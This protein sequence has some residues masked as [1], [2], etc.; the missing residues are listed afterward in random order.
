MFLLFLQIGLTLK[1]EQ[2][3]HEY[4]EYKHEKDEDEDP[5]T[6]IAES[7][8]EASIILLVVELDE[9]EAEENE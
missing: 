3:S 2:G 8:I 5:S 7:D 1:F 6:D 4:L 9:G